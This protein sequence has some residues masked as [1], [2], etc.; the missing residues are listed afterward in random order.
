VGTGGLDGAG[1]LGE[2]GVLAVCGG[3]D[4]GELVSVGGI[5][6]ICGCLATTVD[7]C[8]V[9]TV[10]EEVP[11]SLEGQQCVLTEEIHRYVSCFGKG[12]DPAGAREGFRGCV[13]VAGDLLEDGVGGGW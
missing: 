7:Y 6:E 2:D 8:G 13:E 12:L 1:G 10:A 11:D 9:V 5:V 3:S 4:L